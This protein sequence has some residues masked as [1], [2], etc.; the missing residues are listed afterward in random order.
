ME[1]DAEQKQ[2]IL[3]WIAAVIGEDIRSSLP[4]EKILKDGTILCKLVN[5]LIPGN[6]KKVNTKGSN[7]ALMENL[8][9]VQKAMR[10]YGL[11]EDELFQPVDLFEARNVKAVVKSLSALARL[12]LNKGFDGPSFGPKMSQENRREFTEE[13]MRAG[14]DGHI[15]LQAGYNKGANQAGINMGKQRSVHD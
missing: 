8:A 5:K 4:F 11:P 7:F 10:L 3:D 6:I 2:Q 13:Q 12:C 9:A 14:R 15:G 1:D